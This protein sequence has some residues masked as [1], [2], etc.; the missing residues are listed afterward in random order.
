MYLVELNKKFYPVPT[1]WNELTGRQ[2]VRIMGVLHGG[3]QP[4]QKQLKLLQILAG[5]GSVRFFFCPVDELQDKLYLTVFLLSTN[6][7]TKNLIPAYDGKFGPA[8]NFNNLTGAEFAHTEFYFVK[9]LQ[10]TDDTTSLDELVGTLYRDPRPH[11]DH[12]TNPAGDHRLGFNDKILDHYRQGVHRWP[13][14]LK[15]AVFTWYAGCRA[16]LTKEFPRVFGGAS[17]GEQP[18]YGLWSILRSIAEKG[19]HGTF[20]EVEKM[21]VKEVMMELTELA[22][23]ADRIESISKQPTT[24]NH[25]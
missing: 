19:N 3:L 16:Q 15:L 4:L 8:D 7:L 2:L 10:S 1:T 23:E 22:L 18:Q 25:E 11:Y 14:A 21:L 20:K 17:D 9:C 12:A 13:R 24:A 5:M 6:Q